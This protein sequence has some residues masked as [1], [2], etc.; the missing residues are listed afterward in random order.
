LLLPKRAECEPLGLTVRD[1][2]A[3]AVLHYVGDLTA[4]GIA[5]QD[6]FKIW[7]PASGYQPTKAPGFEVF[8][9]D[10]AQNCLI[11][12]NGAHVIGLFQGIFVR[13]RSAQPQTS[14]P[15]RYAITPRVERVKL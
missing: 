4:V 9:S 6:L 14:S 13:P 10:T 7:L 15:A 3:V 1:F 12:Q 5:W 8:M 2:E 11:K